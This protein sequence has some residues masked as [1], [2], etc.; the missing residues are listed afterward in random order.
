MTLTNGISNRQLKSILS[1]ENTENC[2]STLNSFQLLPDSESFESKKALKIAF[3][4][5]QISELET[6]IL[7]QRIK[8]KWPISPEK[9]STLPS[10]Y[11]Q[12]FEDLQV[13]I[14]ELK[15]C[16]YKD[17]K[18]LK[19][20]QIETKDIEI[21]KER[22]LSLMDKKLLILSIDFSNAKKAF[23]KKGKKG[24]LSRLFG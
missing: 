15:T 5:S 19:L 10:F 16:Y 23:T 9:Q 20:K 21:N 14:G 4:K 6:H 18:I 17:N 7:L 13:K 2:Q 8:I 12:S 24:L 3:L 1:M 11:H 22:D